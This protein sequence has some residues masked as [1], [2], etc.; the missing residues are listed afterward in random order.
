MPTG[1]QLVCDARQGIDIVARIR[2][3]LLEHLRAGI[4]RGER[5]E[6]AGVE[7]RGFG[8][9]I[10]RLAGARDAKIEHLR[11]TLFRQEDVSGLE[12]TMYD[13]ILVRIGE[14]RTNVADDAQRFLDRHAFEVGRPYDLVQ[15]LAFLQLHSHVYGGAIAVEIVYGDDVRMGQALGLFRLPLQGLERFWM[16][17]ELFIQHFDGNV[18]VA[19]HRL[20][21]A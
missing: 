7:N 9:G 18:G 17:P 11:L 12:V 3:A 20:L 13:A 10:V 6:C 5:P 1:Q 14:C 16:G 19:I 8:V 2:I 15:G 21:L 4:G